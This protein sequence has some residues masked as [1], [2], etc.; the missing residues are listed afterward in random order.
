M[1]RS[2]E[3]EISVLFEFWSRY[4]HSL[5]Y[6]Y[7]W[8][9]HKSIN[10]NHPNYRSNW[11]VDL[12]ILPWDG[13]QSIRKTI[14]RN[15]SCLSILTLIPSTGVVADES[16]NSWRDSKY[17]VQYRSLSCPLVFLVCASLFMS[18]SSVGAPWP[19]IERVLQ[20]GGSQGNSGVISR[21]L[22]TLNRRLSEWTG[23][24][25]P[26]VVQTGPHLL[27]NPLTLYVCLYSS[28]TLLACC[29]LTQ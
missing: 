20:G 5:S 27:T 11:R 10:S 3:W 14:Q 7:P 12:A 19:S 24:P 8:K 17:P 21:Y 1:F 23:L 25:P 16:G 22:N 13:N 18:V 26:K 28:Q 15:G 29:S 4:L 2:S 6:T 9:G